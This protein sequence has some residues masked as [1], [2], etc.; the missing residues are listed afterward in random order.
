MLSILFVPERVEAY[1]FTSEDF[2]FVTWALDTL[3]T[4]TTDSSLISLAAKNFDLDGL[5]LWSRIGYEHAK[6]ALDEIDRFDVSSELQPI[7]EE[8]KLALQDFKWSCY[9]SELGAKYLDA[10]Y[11]ELSVRYAESA[12]SHLDR[13]NLLLESIP[14]TSLTPAPTPMLTFTPI[15]KPSPM[16]APTPTPTPSPIPTL[17]HT[18]NTSPTP[19]GFEAIFAIS[20]L[21]VAYSLKGNKNA[22]RNERSRK[23]E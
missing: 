22:R 11:L 6:Q 10:D 18:A 17:H 8:L 3:D 21:V 1:Y 13:L 15:P 16:L 14:L 19:A 2:E 4:L 7:K 23:D 12:T 20:S 5:E 9:Y